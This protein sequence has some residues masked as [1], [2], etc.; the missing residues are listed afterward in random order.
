M[1]R[2][3]PQS[4]PKRLAEGDGEAAELLRKVERQPRQAPSEPAAWERT[5]RR[6]GRDSSRGRLRVAMAAA[7]GATAVAGTVALYVALSRPPRDHAGMTVETGA[8]VAG[9][10]SAATP[11]PRA[12]AGPS[13]PPLAESPKSG[14][15][16]SAPAPDRTATPAAGGVVAANGTASGRANG[17]ASEGPLPHSAADEPPQG[18]PTPA[19]P[20]APAEAPR[21]QLGRAAVGLPA[22]RTELLGEAEVTL[23]RG[24]RATAF[25]TAAAATVDLDAGEAELAVEKRPAGAGHAFEVTAGAYRFTVLGTRFRVVRANGQ[26]TLSVTEGRVAVSR[27]AERL[28]EVTAGGFW[29]STAAPRAARAGA[30]GDS[31]ANTIAVLALRAPAS[32]PRGSAEAGE[33]PPPGPV[34]RSVDAQRMD[35]RAQAP[36]PL[37][38]ASLAPPPFV[39]PAPVP[40]STPGVRARA[41]AGPSPSQAQAPGPPGRGSQ[42]CGARTPSP[43]SSPALAQ[44]RLACLLDEARGAD[45]GAEVALYEAARIYRDALGDT[46]HAIATLRELRRRFPAG[47]LS[48]EAALS[49]VEL[50]PRAGRY[51]EALAE[52]VAVLGSRPA[53]ARADEIHLMRGD[54]LRGG[55]GDCR[56]ALNEY[57]QVADVARTSIADSALFYGAVCLQTLGDRAGARRAFERY[58][59]RPAPRHPAEATRFLRELDRAAAP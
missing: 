33:G 59:A 56:S 37:D 4:W 28:T 24:G 5:L 2:E 36:L 18:E 13:S 32:G 54:L 48:S 50:L 11:E 20:P 1:R 55:L 46:D 35:A 53:P 10:T 52:S 51:R 39:T 30:D 21:I 34:T 40:S 15:T 17:E 12:V 29:A 58:L 22:G 27:G 57:A 44:S 19:D 42:R 41:A 25:A 23:S 9:S 6:L 8:R 43:G 47:A 14:A 3:P 26:V 31:R 16:G 45:L 7:A 49:L 38:N